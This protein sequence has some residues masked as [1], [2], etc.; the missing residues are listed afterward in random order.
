MNIQDALK[1]LGYLLLDREFWQKQRHM[2]LIDKNDD[3]NNDDDDDD[4]DDDNNDDD[5][6]DKV[7]A[8]CFISLSMTWFS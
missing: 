2:R 4:N 3:D 7:Y 6:D 5:N 8:S 1:F